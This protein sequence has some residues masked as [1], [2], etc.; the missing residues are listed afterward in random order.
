[1]T[2]PA[3]AQNQQANSQANQQASSQFEDSALQAFKQEI[4]D[5]LAKTYDWRSPQSEVLANAILKNSNEFNHDMVWGKVKDSLAA[6]R[7][8]AGK[9]AWVASQVLSDSQLA[10]LFVQN[11]DAFVKI[12]QAAGEFTASAFQAQRASH[13]VRGAASL[14]AGEFTASAFQALSNPQ[15]AALFIKD[16][17]LVIK[18]FSKIIK[19]AGE[20][21]GYAFQALF[22]PQL[23]AL[24]VQ[25]PDL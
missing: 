17:D 18:S 4:T 13:R 1:M 11:P 7:N 12:A 20:Y 24:F 14:A 15:L 10:T 21:A 3:Q 16:P 19:A 9:F 25:N 2:V 5:Y 22:N 6:I 8:A 23:A